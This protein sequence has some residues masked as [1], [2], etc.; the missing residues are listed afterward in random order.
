MKQPGVR[1]RFTRFALIA[2]AVAATASAQGL[3]TLTGTVTTVT[4]TPVEGL[5]LTFTGADAAVAAVTDGD[6]DYRLE[7]LEP[8]RYR[9]SIEDP[10]Q[11]VEP[12]FPVTVVADITIRRDFTLRSAAD[13]QTRLRGGD[14][15]LGS[16]PGLTATQAN[17][18][19]FEAR[20]H[21]VAVFL[22]QVPGVAVR[23]AGGW[24]SR[25]RWGC[26]GRR[27]AAASC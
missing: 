12:A 5:R 17:L 26:G 13:V 11:A 1:V 4:G 15:L 10:A 14:R 25:P 19:A 2:W 23:R 21:S 22:R 9:P 6:G 18:D 16:G 7:R 8:G 27:S 20:E 3:G 24:A